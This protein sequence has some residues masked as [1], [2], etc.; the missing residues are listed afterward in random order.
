MLNIN[1]YVGRL[2]KDPVLKEL[3]GD[4]A[5]LR[6]SI[7][8]K[9]EF[10][11]AQNEYDA[12]FIPCVVW[13][14]RAKTFAKTLS[15]GSLISIVGKL[16]SSNYVDPE[17]EKTRYNLEVHVDELGYLDSKPKVEETNP[18]FQL[19]ENPLD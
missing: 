18:G 8:V 4:N 2:T 13:G 15:K 11:N 7:A 5:F 14:A 19:S 9:R 10:K 17:T 12:D 1:S 3:E 16:R 6:F